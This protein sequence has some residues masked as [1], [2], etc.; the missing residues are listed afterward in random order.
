MQD[1]KMMDES[2]GLENDVLEFARLKFDSVFE[3]Q[4]C[5]FICHFQSCIFHPC[6]FDGLSFSI[7]AFSSRVLFP[8]I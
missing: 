4:P 6:D 7:R 1:G 3:F 2:A 5:T 8:V